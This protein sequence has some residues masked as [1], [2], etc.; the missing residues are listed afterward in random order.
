MEFSGSLWIT[1][2]EIHNGIAIR[3]FHPILA[4]FR[5]DYNSRP[6]FNSPVS[7]SVL[8]R[9]RHILNE[10]ESWPMRMTY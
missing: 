3:H 1:V 8:S 9:F 6:F 4:H 10:P 2:S 7:E 5:L